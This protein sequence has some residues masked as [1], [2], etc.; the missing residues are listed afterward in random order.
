MD[1]CGSKLM[2]DKKD[3]DYSF[4]CDNPRRDGTCDISACDAFYLA[5]FLNV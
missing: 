2:S 5:I 3:F 4:S 1:A